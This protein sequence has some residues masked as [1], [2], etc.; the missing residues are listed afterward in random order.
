MAEKKRRTWLWVLG[1]ILCFPIPLTILM[2]RNKKLPPAVR[3]GIIG[4]AWAVLLVFG[5]IGSCSNKGNEAVVEEPATQEEAAAQKQEEPKETATEAETKPAGK[6]YEL[7]GADLGEYGTAVVLNKDTDMPV[8]KH[9]YKLPAGKYKVTTT[10]EKVSS[11][12]IVKDEVGIEEGNET[13][14]ENLVYVDANGYLLTAGDNDFNGHAQ[15][16]VVIELAA[17]ES[18]SLPTETDTIIVE[19]VIE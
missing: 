11:F 8:E 14:P 15:K 9:L 12:Y 2:L 3:Y 4:A 6:I 10:N 17:D 7:S 1:W 16:E 13:Y 5:L 19:E 18:I